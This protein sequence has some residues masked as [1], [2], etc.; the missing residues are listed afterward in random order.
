MFSTP[1][2]HFP[3][4]LYVNIVLSIARFSNASFIISLPLPPPPPSPSASS[5]L[6][7]LPR[8]LFSSLLFYFFLAFFC[9]CF[10]SVTGSGKGT[11]TWTRHE[12]ALLCALCSAT[13]GPVYQSH[14]GGRRMYVLISFLSF[15]PQIL[16]GGFALAFDLLHVPRLQQRR[17]EAARKKNT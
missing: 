17:M 4:H 2:F 6:C 7:L 5:P 14:R 8:R 1:S 3:R 15:T 10:F 11:R 12:P 13:R 9:F 16:A